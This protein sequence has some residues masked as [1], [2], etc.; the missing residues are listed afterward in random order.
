MEAEQK[1]KNQLA[2]PKRNIRVLP[3]E[4]AQ[5]SQKFEQARLKRLEELEVK[6]Q[7]R[8]KEHSKKLRVHHEAIKEQWTHFDDQIIMEKKKMQIL[9][10]HQ[11]QERE[12]LA[13]KRQDYVDYVRDEFQPKTS[14]D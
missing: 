5:H 10:E 11:K 6:R 8:L 13:K 14:E 7:E 1:E 4:I 2:R 12:L 9:A 3:D